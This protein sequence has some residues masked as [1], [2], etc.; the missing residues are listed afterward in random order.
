[1]FYQQITFFCWCKIRA[2]GGNEIEGKLKWQEYGITLT[3][4]M[5][6]RRTCTV[7]KHYGAV[8]TYKIQIKLQI[9]P[10]NQRSTSQ[11]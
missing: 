6:F 9:V 11:N 7:C 5:G 1:V 10:N 3:I 2:S 4:L 8:I